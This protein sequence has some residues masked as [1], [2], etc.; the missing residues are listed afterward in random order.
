V[1]GLKGLPGL[2]GRRQSY[3]PPKVSEG[4]NVLTVTDTTISYIAR[5]LGNDGAA[6]RVAERVVALQAEFPRGT[7]PELIVYQW[8]EQ[9][10][11]R[12]IYQA[13]A[14]GGRAVRGG[15]LPDF[16]VIQGG[17]GAAWQ[18]QGDYWHSKKFNPDRDESSRIR[19]LGSEF[20]G[21]KVE[22]VIFI[23]EDRLYRTYPTPLTMALAGVEV[24]K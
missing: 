10:Q 22:S 12:F 16:V 15:L 5:L 1:K 3:K 23:W 8:L 9:E 18:M 19:L 13:T 17:S 20:E 2:G 21:V 24:G 14:F 4:K 6:W 7:I 11:V